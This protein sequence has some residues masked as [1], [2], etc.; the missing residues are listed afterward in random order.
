MAWSEPLSFLLGYL[1][2]LV[3]A[4]YLQNHKITFLVVSG[5]LAGLA[6]L[7]RYAGIAY[8]AAGFFGLL[9]MGIGFLK[10][11]LVNGVIYVFVGILPGIIWFIRNQWVA[12][13]ATNREIVYHPIRLAKL[14]NGVRTLASWLLI[15]DSLSYSL[16]L[17]IILF[18]VLGS[19]VVFYLLVRRVEAWTN[20]SF[21]GLWALIPPVFRLIGIYIVVYFGFLVVS[22]SFV[23]A[24]TPLDDRILSSIF[25]GGSILVFSFLVR[26]GM[27]GYRRLSWIIL[28]GVSFFALVYALRAGTF[29][30]DGYQKGIGMNSLVWQ[31]S[32]T[33]AQV[34][35]LP[36][37]IPIYSNAAEAVYLQTDHTA[38]RLPRKIERVTSQVNP[39]YESI[40]LDMELAFSQQDGVLVYFDFFQPAGYPSEEELV[41]LFSLNILT[42]SADGTIYSGGF[43]P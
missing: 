17:V 41:E 38:Q 42:K 35:N 43:V 12:G 23:D 19:L 3:L 27:A 20:L 18:L 30:Q 16:L 1:S 4:G 29:I 33:I 37:H 32:E 5:L 21:R 22:I 28:A 8:L 31:Q 14:M 34:R 10:K 9:L 36:L 7:T 40:L 26:L 15:P 2:L 6:I 39:E 24:N 11:R 25:W 13:T